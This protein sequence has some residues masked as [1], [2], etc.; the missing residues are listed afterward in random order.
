MVYQKGEKSKY[1]FNM[2]MILVTLTR[3]EDKD[4]N[5]VEILNIFFTISRMKFN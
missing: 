4:D 2:L 3:S 5:M 1:L